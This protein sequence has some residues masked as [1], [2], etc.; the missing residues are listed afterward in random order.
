LKDKV[1][2]VGKKEATC[3]DPIRKIARRRPAS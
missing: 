3:F 2:D 1:A